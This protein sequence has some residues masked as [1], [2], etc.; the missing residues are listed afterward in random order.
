MQARI[1]QQT[2]EA[3]RPSGNGLV[4]PTFQSV[5]ERLSGRSS[6]SKTGGHRRGQGSVGGRL[7]HTKGNYSTTGADSSAKSRQTPNKLATLEPLETGKSMQAQACPPNLLYMEDFDPEI[8]PAF[9]KKELRPFFS[10]V[11]ADL[12]LRSVQPS[13][14][15]NSQKAI[16]KVTFLEY[17]NLP[18]IV[19]D[20][21]HHLACQGSADGRVLE[22]QF[23]ELMLEVFS[24]SVETKMR[25]TFKM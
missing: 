10:S 15:L 22:A 4:L 9:I 7:Q 19:G 2:Q 20:R 14:A 5:K 23:I 8:D 25:L 12:A 21:F 18:G 13:G 17:V 1:N 11:F 6:A 3:R 24:S 16:D